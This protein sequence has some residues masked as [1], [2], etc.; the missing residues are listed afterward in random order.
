MIPLDIG[1]KKKW[2]NEDNY[3]CDLLSYSTE[4]YL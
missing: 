1:K 2:V 3:V 4:Y